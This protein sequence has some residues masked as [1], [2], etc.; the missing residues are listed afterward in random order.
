M[1]VADIPQIGQST[2]DHT[3]EGV[4][5]DAPRLITEWI[6]GYRDI[7]RLDA[8]YERLGIAPDTTQIQIHLSLQLDAALVPGTSTVENEFPVAVAA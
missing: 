7:G 6:I 3:L 1:F 2:W 8:V 4:L 5:R